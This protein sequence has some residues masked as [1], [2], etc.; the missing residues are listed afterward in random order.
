MRYSP[1]VF[2]RPACRRISRKLNRLDSNA[3]DV[4]QLCGGQI[5]ASLRRSAVAGYAKASG[6]ASGEAHPRP[7]PLLI[8]TARLPPAQLGTTPPRDGRRKNKMRTLSREIEPRRS[9]RSS[10]ACP[11]RRLFADFLFLVSVSG[12]Q[13]SQSQKCRDDRLVDHGEESLFIEIGSR[14]VYSFASARPIFL[15]LV[16][17]IRQF[18][19][20]KVGSFPMVNSR[21]VKRRLGGTSW[22]KQLRMGCQSIAAYSKHVPHR[23]GLL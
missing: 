6:P 19:G 13:R 1:G 10:A 4:C 9:L 7:K 20:G 2:D 16:T 23:T 3:I 21:L 11:S 22:G 14:A 18:C 17:K 15:P 5:V 8:V 12:S